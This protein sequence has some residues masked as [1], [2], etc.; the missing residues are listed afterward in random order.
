MAKQII[1]TDKAPQAIGTYSQAVRVDRTVYLSGQIPLVPET[2]TIIE[3]DISA[4]I[5]Q[6]FDN[7]QAVAEAAGGDFSDIVK[8]NVFLTD[9]AHFPLVNEIMGRYFQ[10]P[11]PARAAIGV[12]ALPKAADVEMDAIMILKPQEYPAC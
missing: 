7:L 9:L 2:M 6:V 11:Y 4:Q 10:A 3:G 8:L 1:Q 12:A 5:T